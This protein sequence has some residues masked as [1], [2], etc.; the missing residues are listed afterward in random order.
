MTHDASLTEQ[1]PAPH[2]VSINIDALANTHHQRLYYFVL[3]KVRNHDTAQ[4]LVQATYV[5]A[6]QSAERFLGHS[7]PETWL[8]GIALN[9]VRTHMH[10]QRKFGMSS[11]DEIEN[12]Q[13]FTEDTKQSE[14]AQDIERRDQI[15]KIAVAFTQM[16]K[17][18][19]NTAKLVLLDNL[20]YQEVADRENIPVG[21][22]R[23]RISR[24]REFLN[25][26]AA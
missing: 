9:L 2:P 20:S 23:S 22:V 18:M 26:A 21:T 13:E 25:R 5:E 17:D 1:T 4:D 3:H 16:P 14:M 12:W 8:I 19:A 11:L 15:K 7:K 10:R 24:A 6:I